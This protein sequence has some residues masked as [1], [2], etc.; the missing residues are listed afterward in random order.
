MEFVIYWKGDA[1]HIQ[2]SGNRTFQNLAL[3]F[4]TVWIGFDV[5]S[6]L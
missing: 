2:L 6:S 3:A 4:I 1:F 5:I